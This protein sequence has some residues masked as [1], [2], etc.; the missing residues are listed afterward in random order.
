VA[1]SCISGGCL[2]QDRVVGEIAARCQPQEIGM[3]GSISAGDQGEGRL[4]VTT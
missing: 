3:R 4:I 2:F 1:W